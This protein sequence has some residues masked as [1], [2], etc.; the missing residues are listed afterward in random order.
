MSELEVRP[1]SSCK[2]NTPFAFMFRQVPIT[3]LINLRIK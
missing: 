1:D 3:T 2:K